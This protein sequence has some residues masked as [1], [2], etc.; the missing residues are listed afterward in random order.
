MSFVF[1]LSFTAAYNKKSLWISTYENVYLPSYVFPMKANYKLMLN[2]QIY[3][4]NEVVIIHFPTLFFVSIIWI[5]L[6]AL[7]TCNIF[8]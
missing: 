2:F 4:A 6:C 5:P 7:K 3:I 8:S 1:V